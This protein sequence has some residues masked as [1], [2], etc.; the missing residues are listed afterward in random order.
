MTHE[1]HGVE[2]RCP[3][4]PVCFILSP[5]ALASIIE[6]GDPAQRAAAVRTIASS[7]SLRTQRAV[8]S[9]LVRALDTDVTSLG[10]LPAPSGGRQAIYDVEHGGR[11]DLPGR[12]VRGPDDG[13]VSDVA[14]NEAFD[15]AADTWTF[16]REVFDRDSID[17]QGAELVSSVHY[18]VGFDLSLIHI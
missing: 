12:L 4:R 8:V 2:H 5:D 16:Y 10:L 6:E 18:G 9:T 14:V 3:S 7:A 15:G 17:G 11:A 13:P 1:T